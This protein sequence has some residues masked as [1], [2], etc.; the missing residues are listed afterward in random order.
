MAADKAEQLFWK[1][2]FWAILIAVVLGVV[3]GLLVESVTA[4]IVIYVLLLYAITAYHF[5]QL[6]SNI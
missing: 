4:G 1:K 2:T 3:I 6:C 5:Y